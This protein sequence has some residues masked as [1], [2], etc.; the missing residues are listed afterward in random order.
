[1]LESGSDDSECF[2]RGTKGTSRTLTVSESESH[3]DENGVGPESVPTADPS[4]APEPSRNISFVI[5]EAEWEGIRPPKGA[6][7]DARNRIQMRGYGGILR[8]YIAQSN[9]H[10]VLQAKEMYCMKP[11]GK[12]RH[13]WAFARMICNDKACGIAYRL[14]IKDQP[15]EG[16][17]T[18]MQFDA[19]L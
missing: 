13:G 1:M 9:P 19:V 12:Q 4:L 15:Q 8:K 18:I 11:Q 6:F 2:I 16:V 7:F 10:C 14:V 3:S 17:R 5:S